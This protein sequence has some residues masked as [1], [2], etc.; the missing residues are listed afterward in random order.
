VCGNGGWGAGDSH[1]KIPDAR[2]AR[3]SQHPMGLALAEIL[4]KEVR[5]SIETIFR[6]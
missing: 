5:E 4:N 1:Q 2:K 6:G 3:G